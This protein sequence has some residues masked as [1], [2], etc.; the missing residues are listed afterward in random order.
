[1]DTC[2]LA[3]GLV[4]NWLEVNSVVVVD[5][6]M[7]PLSVI[8]ALGLVSDD[9]SSVLRAGGGEGAVDVRLARACE[10]CLLLYE[11]DLEADV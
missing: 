9:G 6:R 4:L 5:G 1:M 10:R 7:C 3:A 8:K 2:I 11:V